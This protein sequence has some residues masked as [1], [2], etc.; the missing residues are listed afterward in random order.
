MILRIYI[1]DDIRALFLRE[2]WQKKQR[3]ALNRLHLELCQA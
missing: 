3:L 2:E 1:D